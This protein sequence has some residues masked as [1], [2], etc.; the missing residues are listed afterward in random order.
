M[1]ISAAK[2]EEIFCM[3]LPELEMYF[4]DLYLQSLGHN[5]VCV[6]GG[7]GGGC[8]V[9]TVHMHFSY[10]NPI[11]TAQFIGSTILSSLSCWISCTVSQ[12]SSLF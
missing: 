12:E 3:F 1:F 11:N 4:L 2:G 6:W 7:G 8:C 9:L 5:A 10:G